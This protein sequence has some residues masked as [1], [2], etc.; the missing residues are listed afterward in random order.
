MNNIDWKKADK[1]HIFLFIMM[2]VGSFT[3]LFFVDTS[4]ILEWNMLKRIIGLLT[5]WKYLC[6]D[7]L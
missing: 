1:L 2:V 5:I 7:G 3:L 6:F 4:L